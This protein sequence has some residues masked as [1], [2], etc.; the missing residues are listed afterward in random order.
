MIVRKSFLLERI[1]LCTVLSISFWATSAI[2]QQTAGPP[3]AQI[4]GLGNIQNIQVV[5]SEEE[6]RW[7]AEHHTVRVR[8]G[9]APPYSFF[10][11]GPLG[12]SGDYLNTV[13]QR[14]G[15]QVKYI[16]DIPWPDALKH[17]ANR[18]AIDVL[19]ALTETI[20]RKGYIVFTQPYLTSPRVIFV[21]EDSG[22]IDSLEDLANRTISVERGYFLQQRL[23]DD[24]P[25]IQLLIRE[26]TEEALVSLSVGEADAYV[27]NLVASTYVIRNRGLTN[28]KIA[29][30]APFGKLTLSMGV[31][32]DWPELA[33]IVD[34]V[35]ASLNHTEHVAIRDKWLLPIRYEYGIRT[36]DILK[37]TLGISS[38]ALAIIITV[39]TSNKR[40]RREISARQ[41]AEAEARTLE[42]LLPICAVCKKIQ[43][44]DGRWHH[45]ESYISDRSKAMF[46]HGYCPDCYERA[47]EEAEQSDRGD[48]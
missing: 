41:K 27:G 36:A 9:K 29:A 38:I 40:L 18:E 1:L 24:Y 2:P 13:A 28:I 10:R 4:Q 44:E 7:L 43:D 17:I 6:Q 15:F 33:S 34:K 35:L 30:P 46:S 16:P 39:L 23:A 25:D 26:T 12:I 45:M 48:S 32:N 19:P 8:V 3:S 5:F 47:I 20:D 14:A 42:G 31:R 11:E 22:F 21:R 37:W